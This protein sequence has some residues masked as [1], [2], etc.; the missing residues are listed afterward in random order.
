MT[1][2]TIGFGVIFSRD[3]GPVYILMA[4]FTI[5]PYIA[6]APGCLFFMAFKAGNGQ[7]GTVEREGPQ[8]MLFNSVGSKRKT[9]HAMAGGTIRRYPVFSKLLLVIICMAI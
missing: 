6:E 2:C 4:V 7:V 8:V 1:G 5:D 9:I 3:I